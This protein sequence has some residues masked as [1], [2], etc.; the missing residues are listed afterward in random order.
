VL[1]DAYYGRVANYL[2]RRLHGQDHAVLSIANETLLVVWVKPEGYDGTSLFSTYLIGMSNYKLAQHLSRQGKN[3]DDITNTLPRPDDDDDDED[4]GP[5]SPPSPLELLLKKEQLNVLSD[6]A[7]K[8]LN[9]LQHRV[10]MGRMIFGLK[11]EEL[12][13]ELQRNAVTLRRAFMIALDK[14]TDCVQLRLGISATKKGR[15]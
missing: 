12:A 8:H 5:E 10:F 7:D 4:F 14:A 2:R 13:Q 6:C 3:L 9:P 15:S 11:I 1:Y